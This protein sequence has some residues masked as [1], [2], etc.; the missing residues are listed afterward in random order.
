MYYTF[1]INNM[2]CPSAEEKYLKELV[3]NWNYTRDQRNKHSLYR[4]VNYL[5]KPSKVKDLILKAK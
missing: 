5:N 2:K 3:K 4:H 1:I